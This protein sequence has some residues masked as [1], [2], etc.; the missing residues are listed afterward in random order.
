MLSPLELVRQSRDPV[1][2]R[3]CF[4]TRE[5][6]QPCAAALLSAQDSNLESPGPKPGELP[7]ALADTAAAIITL[8][9]L[10]AFGVVL[11]SFMTVPVRE[12][13]IEP[14]RP[15]SLPPQGSAFTVSPLT[16]GF[17]S[18]TRTSIA[19]VRFWHPAIRRKGIKVRS[20]GFEPGA[21]LVLGQRG[22]P[23]A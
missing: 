17:P 15:R 3:T 5:A 13:G 7:V 18:R 1:P 14:A 11:G 6:S 23:V 10:P 19:R 16:Q 22:R 9:G 21:S 20:P 12:A 4:L 8:T 2:A